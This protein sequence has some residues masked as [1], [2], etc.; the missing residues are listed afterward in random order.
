MINYNYVNYCRD[1]P[2]RGDL[3]A[4]TRDRAERA[5]EPQEDSQ[6]SS[7]SSTRLKV[8]C[9]LCEFEFTS[10]EK[11]SRKMCHCRRHVHPDCFAGDGD[12]C[13]AAPK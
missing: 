9:H 5:A 3:Q 7:K 8:K 12:S 10:T 13:P 6:S 1:E 4:G 2:V 11:G